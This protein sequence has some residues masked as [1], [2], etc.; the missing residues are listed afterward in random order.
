MFPNGRGKIENHSNIIQHILC[1]VL[2]EAG[3][4][5][6]KG[7]G[8]H[9]R[10]APFLRLVVHQSAGR[11]RARIA[12]ESRSGAARAF[13]NRHDFGRLR[14]PIPRG[15]DGSEMAEAEKLLMR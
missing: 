12:Y 8:G 2:V 5:N 14:P 9:A 7:G 1:P 3:V 11:W 6:A 13:L 15:D 10:H 4:V